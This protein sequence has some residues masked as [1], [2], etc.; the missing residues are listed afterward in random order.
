VL[1]GTGFLRV[2]RGMA[3]LALPRAAGTS[4]V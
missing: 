1:W 4:A 3:L 2:A